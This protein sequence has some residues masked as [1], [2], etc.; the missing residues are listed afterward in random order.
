MLLVRPGAR[1][2]RP[3]PTADAMTTTII[4]STDA[5]PRSVPIELR[6]AITPLWAEPP[7]PD[8]AH[9]PKSGEFSTPPARMLSSVGPR[10]LPRGAQS[11]R[12]P[13]EEPAGDVCVLPLRDLAEDAPRRGE[14]DRRCCIEV[15]IGT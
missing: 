13:F 7:R 5:W 14:Q 15:E 8:R 1:S 10:S 12:K 3:I 9:G 11:V 4:H 6:P 2:T